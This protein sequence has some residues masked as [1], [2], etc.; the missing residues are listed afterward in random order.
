MSATLLRG[1]VT[2]QLLGIPQDQYEYIEAPMLFPREN[3]LVY[4]Y[5][6]ARMGRKDRDK[7]IPKIIQAVDQIIDAFPQGK[8]LVHCHSYELAEKLY[9]A[10]RHAGGRVFLQKPGGTGMIEAMQHLTNSK[11]P[12]VVLSPTM[13]E[14]V[15]MPDVL[16]FQIIPVMPWPSLKDQR[17]RK[18]MELSPIWYNYAT[19]MALMQEVGRGV[20]NFTQVCPA[21]VL[22][23]NFG[24]F[25]KDAQ[26]L[27]PQTFKEAIVW[28]R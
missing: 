2:A 3:R 20:R 25:Y 10:S 1:Q 6:I 26:D 19:A 12:L 24:H 4:Y 14:G 27:M 5:N 9:H 22:D 13:E 11:Q 28:H 15:D 16:S 18:R 7:S 17:V 23:S 21:Y 8:G